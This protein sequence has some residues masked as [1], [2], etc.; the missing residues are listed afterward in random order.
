MGA[1][2]KTGRRADDWTAARLLSRRFRTRPAAS[3]LVAVLALMTVMVAA[4]APRLIEQQATSEL[5]Y[6]LTAAGTV[7][8]S[9]QGVANFPE[10]W[11]ALP[12]P[13][14]AQLYDGLES[15]FDSARDAMP[16]PLRGLV[17]APRWIVQTPTIPS[18]DV[19]GVERLVGL[20]LTAD[21]TYLSRIRFVHG[22]APATWTGNDVNPTEQ[23]AAAPVDIALS[24]ASAAALKVAVGEL[25]SAG[26][27]NGSP[28]QLY[29]V[30]GLFEPRD[31]RDDYWAENSSLLPATTALTERGLPFLSAAAFVDPLTVGRLSGDFGSAQ[32]A[33]Y[34]PVAAGPVDGADA[35]RLQ[36]QL[37][38]I[39]SSGVRLP[40]SDR[41]M[42]LVSRSES[43]IATAVERGA[44][45]A[46]LLALLA[47]A[48]IGVVLA[49]LVLGVQVVVRGRRTELLLA[50]ARGASPLQLRGAMAFEG[51]LLSIPAATVA[52]TLIAILIPAR[53]EPAGILLPLL[54]ALV[55]PVLFAAIAA[56]SA[57]PGPLG[58]VIGGLRGVAELAVVLL[59]ALALFL[60]ARRGLAQATVAVGVDPLLSVTPLLL[61]VSVGIL[62]L[63][64]FPI[65]MRAARLAAARSR[66]LV[67]FIGSIGASRTPTIGLA[68]ILAL[69]VG[70]SVSL[71]ST[72]LLT[73][74]DDGIH[75]AT[76]EAVGA[77]ARIESPAFND[78]QRGAVAHVPGVLDVA[79]L[80]YLASQDVT[81]APITDPVTLILA[82]TRPLSSLRTL[83]ADLTSVS[84]GRVPVVVSS[85]LLQTLGAERTLTVAGVDARVVGS[86]PSRSALGPASDWVIADAAFASRFS[87]VFTPSTLLIRA[88]PAHLPTMQGPLERA[89]N[90]DSTGAEATVLTVP[91]AAAVRQNEP[92]VRGVEVGLILGAA[93]SVLLCAIAL[94]LST[95]AAGTARGRTAGILRTLGMPRRRL[96]ALIAWELVP[97]AVVTLV[98]GALLGIAL[99]FVVASAVDLRA[100]T[101]SIARPIPVLDPLL[102]LGVLASFLIVVVASGLAAIA[103]GDR[104]SPS[105]TLKMGAS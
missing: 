37:S 48:P 40:N 93:L 58:R 86:L 1:L 92:A 64:G 90:A 49:V 67:G 43:A 8:R 83:P 9:L 69:V 24:V 32:I 65:P 77:D 52:T 30:A 29:R 2:T 4:A 73:T 42:S 91:T 53:P 62:V 98:A 25:I 57:Q 79:G 7:G 101:G 13:T 3:I 95:L 74:F 84:D 51:A 104:I 27:A 18:T 102:L 99:P 88:D 75:R 50:S 31:P 36:S 60:L 14:E 76:T 45:L 33:L 38:S 61:A 26:A 10:D 41:T 70:V 81:Q 72:V 23:S 5:A 105:S 44:L 19:G 89:V 22:T 87:T 47:A 17:G 16:Q 21:R 46:G 15:A 12:P 34:Y 11:D 6:Q 103:V 20:R 63:H 96:G 97:V 35:G 39:T 55:L 66:D 78:A 82:E 54:A 28:T 68:G 94:V 56:T 71:F 80:D 85:D 100:F 59:A